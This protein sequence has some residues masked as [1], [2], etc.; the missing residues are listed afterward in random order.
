MRLQYENFV[1]RP[2]A[3]MEA[4]AAFIGEPRLSM[5]GL[6]DSSVTL[7]PQHVISGNPMR[8]ESGQVPIVQDDEWKRAMPARQYRGVTAITAPLLRVYGYPLTRD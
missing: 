7:R 5:V 4:V 2:L 1:D 3:T 8:E 6:S